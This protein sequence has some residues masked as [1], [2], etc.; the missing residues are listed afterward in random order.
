MP[1]D[2]PVLRQE[3]LAV[4]YEVMF[5]SIKALTH[6]DF[7]RHAIDRLQLYRVFYMLYWS[8]LYLR[9][10]LLFENHFTVSCNPH[11]KPSYPP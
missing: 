6:D 9:R 7:H 3:Y 5:F 2:D 4:R 11:L 10:L 8:A 1:K